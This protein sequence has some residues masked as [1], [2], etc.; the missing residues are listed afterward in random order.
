MMDWSARKSR[1]FTYNSVAL[2]YMENQCLI[3]ALW[4][5]RENWPIR[6]QPCCCCF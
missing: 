4:R 1:Y 3:L 6:A 2:K 5:A